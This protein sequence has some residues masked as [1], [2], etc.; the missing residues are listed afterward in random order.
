MLCVRR[1]VVYRSCMSPYSRSAGHKCAVHTHRNH[2]VI[3]SPPFTASASAASATVRNFA[4]A[5]DPHTDISKVVVFDLE[6]K[7]VAFSGTYTA[8]IREIFSA[9]G[10]IYLLSNDGKVRRSL[11]SRLLTD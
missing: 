6:N 7:Y 10:Q 1:C 9:D 3:V 11:L 5:A 8:G 4:A 2:L